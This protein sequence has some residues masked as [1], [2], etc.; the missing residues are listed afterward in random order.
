MVD[1]TSRKLKKLKNPFS[2]T[3]GYPSDASDSP[4]P[5]ARCCI[6]AGSNVGKRHVAAAP[7]RSSPRCYSVAPP[8]W[9][10]LPWAAR[11]SVPIGDPIEVRPAPP[12][13]AL[14]LVPC[15]ATSVA[16]VAAVHSAKADW[17]DW[18]VPLGTEHFAVA[19]AAAAAAAQAV[20]VAAAAAVAAGTAVGSPCTAAVGASAARTAA[21]PVVPETAAAVALLA[22]PSQAA[23]IGSTW[24]GN[25]GGHGPLEVC[26]A[27]ETD[28]HRLYWLAHLHVQN[29]YSTHFMIPVY[30]MCS[31]YMC[32]LYILVQTFYISCICMKI[33]VAL[34]LFFVLVRQNIKLSE[35]P[36][37]E[38]KMRSGMDSF[39]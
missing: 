5:A 8:L 13:A 21:V 19:P 11:G 23:R 7:N 33:H 12:L 14:A 9:P 37:H 2:A 30:V 6:A 29:H 15:P 17:S 16:R 20:D 36:N 22:A 32:I 35:T 27:K 18:S 34:A 31:M 38:H 10:P 1:S 3:P 25:P 4:P 26:L 24:L 28:H 39:S